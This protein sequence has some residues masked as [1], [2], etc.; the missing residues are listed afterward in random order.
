MKV[1]IG[2]DHAGFRLKQ[3]LTR[4]LTEMDITYDD[5]GTFDE[6]SVDYPDYGRKVASAVASGAYD[7]GVLVCGTGLGMCI[8]ANKVAG[9]RAV[10]VHDVF[11]A[12]MSRAHNDANV[13]TM[14][15]RIVGEGIAADVL[16]TWLTT[17]F[18]GGRHAKRVDKMMEIE[19]DHAE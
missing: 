1:A 16:K 19:R 4:T 14:G 13:L 2:S 5:L 10:T 11:S 6:Q 9:V 8:T 7:K 3:F 15:E 18:E 12:R 17:E